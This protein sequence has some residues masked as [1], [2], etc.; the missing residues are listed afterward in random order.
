ML[1]GST[2]RT[3]G[4]GQD[5]HIF[6]LSPK[7]W[8][9]SSF[10]LASVVHSE[11]SRYQG[12]GSSRGSFYWRFG[13]EDRPPSPEMLS[14][15]CQNQLRVSVWV[16]FWVLY[17]LLLFIPGG[18]QTWPPPQMQLVPQ[19]GLCVRA[20]VCDLCVSV[21]TCPRQW[22]RVCEHVVRACPCSCGQRVRV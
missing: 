5:L 15:L 9:V 21:E 22:L 14:L 12:Q 4:L 6:Y 16:Y 17:Q 19:L 7:G 3:L 8:L 13:A 11:L 20:G 2:L 1:L 10:L 18:L